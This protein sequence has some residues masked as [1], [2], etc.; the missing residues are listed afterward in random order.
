MRTN[1][2]L[3]KEGFTDIRTFESL[4]KGWGVCEIIGSNGGNDSKAVR[5]SIEFDPEHYTTKTGKESNSV[6]DL[7]IVDESDVTVQIADESEGPACKKQKTETQNDTTAITK[8]IT[9]LPPAFDPKRWRSFQLP[10]RGHTSYITV[11]TRGLA[12][13]REQPRD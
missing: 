2:L 13:E 4:C 1:E 5:G 8:P 7:S 3:R 6:N 10:M 11:A 12:D 9:N